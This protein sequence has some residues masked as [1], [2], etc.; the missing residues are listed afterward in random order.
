LRS[1]SSLLLW[2]AAGGAAALLASP[3]AAQ[4]RS[5]AHPVLLEL[6]GDFAMPL[7]APARDRFLQ[8]GGGS[9]AALFAPSQAAL[10]TVRARVIVLGDGPAPQD[11]E[12]VDPGV[13]TLYT[14]TAGARLRFDGISQSTLEPEATGFWAE[15]DLGVALTGPLAR[16]AFEAAIGYLWDVGATEVDHVD[17]GPVARFVHILQT[18]ERGIDSNSTF[19][20]TLGLDIV[21]WDAAAPPPVDTRV[22]QTSEWRHHHV[23]EGNDRDGDGIDDVDDACP[24]DAEDADGFRDIDG[25]PDT[26]DD[27]DHVL[28]A[29]DECPRD[30]EDADGFEDMDGC[31]DGDNDDDSYSDSIDACPN[32]PETQNGWQDADGCPDVDPASAPVDTAPA[33]TAPA[34]EGRPPT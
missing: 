7:N 28:D 19:V 2:L 10:T 9:A 4:Q 5:A 32:E 29:D 13:G 16:P 33:D 1:S 22:I 26:D 14:I 30:A 27:S 17:I 23:V 21:L 24:A 6:E 25:C 8:G 31:P 20:L 18:E 12:I 11:P 3:A 15:I 34:D